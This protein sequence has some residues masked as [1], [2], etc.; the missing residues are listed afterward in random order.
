MESQSRFESERAAT[1]DIRRELLRA[2]VSCLGWSVLGAVMVG[3]ALHVTDAQAGPIWF[4]GGLAI[5]Y[6]GI[7]YTILRLYRRGLVRGYWT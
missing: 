1:R 4:W 3:E 7:F 6:A 2:A 5:G